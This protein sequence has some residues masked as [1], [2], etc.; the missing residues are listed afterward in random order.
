MYAS[1]AGD[2]ALVQMLIDAGANMDV[3]VNM[4]RPL[5]TLLLGWGANSPVGA[6]QI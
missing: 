3:A 2:E 1:S 6:N 5:F 4:S